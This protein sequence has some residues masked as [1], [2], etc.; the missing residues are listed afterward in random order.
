[1]LAGICNSNLRTLKVDYKSKSRLT[2]GDGSSF[3][4][5]LRNLLTWGKDFSIPLCSSRNDDQF[6]GSIFPTRWE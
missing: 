1:M 6:L 4:P 2:V 3:R 5:Q